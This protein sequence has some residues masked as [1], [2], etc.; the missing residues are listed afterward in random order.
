MESWAKSLNKKKD[1][2]KPT[3]APM[4]PITSSAQASGFIEVKPQGFAPI[5]KREEPIE[6]E[7]PPLENADDT[8]TSPSNLKVLARIRIRHVKIK[9]INMFLKLF[10]L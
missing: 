7:K 1:P 5:E 10:L 4:T 6:Q 9:L 2:K 8:S 3:A